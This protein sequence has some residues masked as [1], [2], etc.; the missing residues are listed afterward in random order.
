MGAVTKRSGAFAKGRASRGPFI[1]IPRAVLNSPAWAAM[2]GHEVKLLLDLAAS[3]R[4][5]SN[6]DLSCAWRVMKP[7]GWSS[8]D[9]LAKALAGLLDK[10]FIVKTRQG[11]KRLC[12]LYA[13][14]WE[15]IDPCDGKLDVKP[16]PVPSNAWR[17]WQPP[18]EAINTPG[19]LNKQKIVD[20]VG[21]LH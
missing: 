7:R 6:G 12:N 11:G 18:L 9:T 17:N 21:G 1:A 10:G 15:A 2:S 4:G 8:R 13:L 3:Y 5:S 20:T 14:S 16:W 19:G